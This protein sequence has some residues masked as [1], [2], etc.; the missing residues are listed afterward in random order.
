MDIEVYECRSKVYC[1]VCSS[2]HHLSI[3]DNNIP[4]RE[5]STRDSIAPSSVGSQASA[6]FCV[7][8]A[9]YGGRAVL[10]TALAILREEDR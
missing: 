4:S 1:N 7:G 10:Q 9:E 3:C 8:N 5:V 6:T 2:R